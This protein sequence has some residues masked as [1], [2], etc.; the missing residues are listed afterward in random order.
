M[1]KFKAH[2]IADNLA[3]AD[4]HAQA[5]SSEKWITISPTKRGRPFPPFKTKP[6]HSGIRSNEPQSFLTTSLPPT[7]AAL[8]AKDKGK[9][10]LV[11]VAHKQ[12]TTLP[13]EGADQ[14]G[15]CSPTLGSFL[16]TAAPCSGTFYGDFSFSPSACS[17]DLSCS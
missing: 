3:S 16:K 6:S 15:P 17:W 2:D 1:E 4:P 7:P 5:E 10:V 8:G 12:S 9:S 11:N 14:A 13:A